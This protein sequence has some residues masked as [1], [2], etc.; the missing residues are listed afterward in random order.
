MPGARICNV[1]SFYGRMSSFGAAAYAASKHAVEAF[2]T[3][4]RQELAP[5]GVHVTIC[6]PG[7]CVCVCAF[8]YTFG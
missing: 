4:L 2:S 8:V 5:D 7:V 1:S 6:E 3:A